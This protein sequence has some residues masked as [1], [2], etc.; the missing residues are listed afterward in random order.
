LFGFHIPKPAEIQ[1]K[2]VTLAILNFQQYQYIFDEE[3]IAKA[4]QKKVKDEQ[5]FTQLNKAIQTRS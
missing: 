5:K 1:S 2:M 4:N 3:T